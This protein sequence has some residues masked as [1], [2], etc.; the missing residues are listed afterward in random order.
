M[1]FAA[2][3]FRLLPLGRYV[4]PDEPAWVHRSI[5]F[6]D[7]L[8]A[9]DWAAVP[10]T[11]HPGVTTMWLGAAGVAI[12]QLLHPA[13]S[14]AHLD[15]V[16]RL[17]WLAPEN[18]EAFRHLAFFL[19]PGRV[20]VAV[21]TTL[22]LLLLYLLVRRLFG[23]EVAL[24]TVG[25]LA[26]DPF[27]VGH[28]G[29]LHTDGLLTTFTALSVIC[30]L[31]AL[32]DGPCQR[33]WSLASGAA[34]GLALLTKSSGVFLVP[35]AIGALGW[36]LISRRT[37]LRHALVLSAGWGI[38]GTAVYLA[39]YPAMWAAPLQTVRDLFQAPSYHATAALM[40]TFF[41]GRVSLY[42]GPEFY[43]VSFLVR[44][45]PVVLI[46]LVPSIPQLLRRTPFRAD[47]AWLWLFALGYTLMLALSVKK[48]DRYLLPI[49]PPLAL[50]VA[51]S[52]PSRLRIS[53]RS[54][55]P[56]SPYLL[57]VAL[58]LLLLLPFAAHPL[59]Y[60]NP[61][62]GGPAV[63]SRLISLDWGEGMGAAARWLNR[64]PEAQG[65]TVAA[66]SVPSFASLFVGRTLPLDDATASLADYLV[67]SSCSSLTQL[68][69]HPVYTVTLTLLPHAVVCTSTAP[70]EQAA[71]LAERATPGDLILLDADAPLLHNYSGPGEIVS[72][73]DLPD[74]VAL[75]A[76]LAEHLPVEGRL[77]TVHLPA[78]SPVTAAQLRRQAGAVATPVASATVAS[79]V[80]TE[81]ATHNIQPAT[82][83]EQQALLALFGGQLAL[84]DSVVPETVARPD[85]LVATIRWRAVGVPPADYRAVVVL[86]DREG[87]DWSQAEDWVLNGSFFPTSDWNPDEWADVAYRLPLPPAISP[88]RY[89]VEVSLYDGGTGAGL[90]ASR[91]DGSFAGT[92]VVVGEVAIAPPAVPPDVDALRISHRLDLPA[93]P[94]TLLGMASPPARVLSG[95]PISFSLFWQANTAPGE[96][97]RVRLRL[98]GGEG[99]GLERVV[100]LS[101]HPTSRWRPGDRF[102]SRHTLHVPP[103]LL[104]GSYRLALNVLDAEG[105]PLWEG[106]RVMATVEVLPRERSFELPEEIPHPLELTFG[107]GIHLL[108]YG[109]DR[110]AA[111]PGETLEL[112]LY[113]QADGPTDRS[114]TLFVHLLGSDGLPHGQADRIP[115]NGLAPT[116]S[117]TAGQ[118]VVE[119]VPLPVAADAPPGGY[120]IAVGFYD[121][122]YGDRLPVTDSTG[123]L[124]PGNQ[125]VLPAEIGI[126]PPGGP[127]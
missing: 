62:L 58:Q 3:F 107:E 43:A 21:T 87:H 126:A 9:R 71:Y 92:R 68:P 41:A 33:A 75:A 27:L 94:L 14:A 34:A 110:T 106:D 78:A 116:S 121:A 17:M 10:S 64:L 29:L 25:L 11:G 108:G 31:G 112:T 113:W 97:Y 85:P 117:W 120:H 32:R 38:G 4:T 40:P 93:G 90:G 79:A 76:W 119:K 61:L 123:H 23:N 66:N 95:D 48:Y 44:F 63:G 124:L 57:L 91:P 6:Y 59:T 12:Q 115:G 53:P 1:L 81:Y 84:V 70:L 5:R 86:R 56:V 74:E 118:V 73:A 13:E 18:G 101:P 19:T 15:W 45:S 28:S 65:L 102:E 104:P 42:H 82:S 37:R 99:I 72:V 80:I 96:D 98:V 55:V 50:A 89:T 52:L 2:L 35:F 127:Q 24:A 111:A 47:R 105:R 103:D 8:I 60:A 51:L 83:S 114:Y 77:W 109:L 30:L 36:R 46:G 39:L 69:S 7:A 125:A 20:A 16:R 54:R 122:A 67:S 49:L 88:G 22:G 100:P 26:F